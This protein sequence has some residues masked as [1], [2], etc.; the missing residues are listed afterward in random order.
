MKQHAKNEPRDPMEYPFGFGFELMKNPRAMQLFFSL[1]DERKRR[2]MKSI[3]HIQSHE[4]MRGFL[5]GITEQ[6]FQSNKRKAP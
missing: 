6:A 3:A 1:D 2:L 4:E 5:E